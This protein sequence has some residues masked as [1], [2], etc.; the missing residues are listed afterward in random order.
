[1]FLRL[2]Q[3]L[4]AERV[5]VTPREWLDLLAVLQSDV[6]PTTPEALHGLARSQSSGITA[7]SA[8]G[9]ANDT[10]CR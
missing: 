10:S 9:E 6:V 7:P 2:F 3:A 8:S 1:M 5:P 4:R